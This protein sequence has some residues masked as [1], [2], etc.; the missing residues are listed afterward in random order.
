[1][2]TPGK[3]PPLPALRAFEAAARLGSV[4][5]AAEELHV[6]HS[7]VSQQIIS[8][9]GSF[10]VK[11]FGRS[12]MNTWGFPLLGCVAGIT[13]HDRHVRLAHLCG[14]DILRVEAAPAGGCA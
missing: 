14:R 9:E 7:A 8:L 2:M 4:T 11:L 1:M 13:V 6:T 5:A 3:L 12:G 10:G